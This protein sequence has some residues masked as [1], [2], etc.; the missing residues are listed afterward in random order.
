MTAGAVVFRGVSVVRLSCVGLIDS[1]MVV[2]TGLSKL[3]KKRSLM[4]VVSGL[5]S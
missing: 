1:V 2:V 4:F 5:D 3:Y